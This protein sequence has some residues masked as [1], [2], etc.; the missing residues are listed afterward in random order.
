M[1]LVVRTAGDPDRVVEQMRQAVRE[2]DPAVAVFEARSMAHYVDVMLYPYRLAATIG[3]AFG[4]LA[5]A[6]AGV[7]IY[8]VIA[9]GVGERLREVAIR[10]ALGAGAAAL[11]KATLGETIRAAAVGVAAG[12]ML[13]FVAGQL[14]ADVLFGISPM[15]PVTLLWTAGLLVAVLVA[16]AA[17]P[18]RRALGVDPMSLLRQ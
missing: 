5:L 17:G 10:L 4:I 2:M 12:A 9:C 13:A 18:V 15:D 6:L 14:L 8:G 3:S 1:R 16:A 7:G 11:M